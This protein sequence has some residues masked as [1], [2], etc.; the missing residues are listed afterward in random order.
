[1]ESGETDGLVGENAGG[2][3]GTADRAPRRPARARTPELFGYIVCTYVIY[4]RS[5]ARASA[6]RQPSHQ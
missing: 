2:N 5:G 3:T 4:R 1:V 6:K